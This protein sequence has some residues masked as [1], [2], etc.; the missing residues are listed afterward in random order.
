MSRPQSDR[1]RV[2]PVSEPERDPAVPEVVRMV[3]GY[4]GVAAGARDPVTDLLVAERKHEPPGRPVLER[5]QRVDLVK[6]LAGDTEPA[7]AGGAAFG[8]R[9]RDPYPFARNIDVAPGEADGF[10]DAEAAALHQT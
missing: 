7:L 8:P 1:R 5:K 2:E 9:A 10:A 4:P 6:E 3:V